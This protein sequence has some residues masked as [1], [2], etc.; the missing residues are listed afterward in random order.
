MAR[1]ELQ[2]LRKK[3]LQNLHL[4]RSSVHNFRISVRNIGTFFDSHQRSSANIQ[5]LKPKIRCSRVRSRLTDH[6][7]VPTPELKQLLVS[8]SKKGSRKASWNSAQASGGHQC[9]WG[10]GVM[11]PRDSYY[12]ATINKYLIREVWSMPNISSHT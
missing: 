1:A 5:L 2:E 9:R 3:R 6:L 7:T 12:R 8:V 10:L 11:E 4:T